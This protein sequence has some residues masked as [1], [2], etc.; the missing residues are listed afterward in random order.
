MWRKLAADNSG[1]AA[2]ELGLL[3]P[4]FTL[5]FLGIFDTARLAERS[6]RVQTLAQN[7]AMAIAALPEIP[8]DATTPLPVIN[9]VDLIDLPATASASAR[10]FRGCAHATGIAV[11]P[12]PFCPDGLHVAPYV[13]VSV[14]MTAPRLVQWPDELLTP[15]VRGKAVMRAG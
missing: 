3:L 2:L 1:V 15:I 4:L 11:A 10:I 5:I 13:E 7:G 8:A 9:V 14:V 6:W 12:S